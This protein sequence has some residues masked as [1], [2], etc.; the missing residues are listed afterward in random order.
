MHLRDRLRP[1]PEAGDHLHRRGVQL[2]PPDFGREHSGDHASKR[3]ERDRLDGHEALCSGEQ[4]RLPA[5]GGDRLGPAARQPHRRPCRLP[6]AQGGRRPEADVLRPA[7]QQPLRGWTP[8][9]PDRQQ[10]PHLRGGRLFAARLPVEAPRAPGAGALDRGAIGVHGERKGGGPS[11]V[12]RILAQARRLARDG[13]GREVSH[14]LRSGAPLVR[15]APRHHVVDAG[16]EPVPLRLSGA[17]PVL[18]AREKP[19]E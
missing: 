4:R 14:V 10:E 13:R 2:R 17:F 16:A 5:D 8:R 11:R 9:G 12:A 19:C 18:A 6:R 1:A 3:A 15:L 7:Q